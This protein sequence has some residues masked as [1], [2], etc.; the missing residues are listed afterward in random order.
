MAFHWVHNVQICLTLF[1]SA[2]SLSCRSKL[3]D[4]YISMRDHFQ[5]F[6]TTV[7]NDIIKT[8]NAIDEYGYAF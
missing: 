6:C 1:T 2:I 3:S 8:R 4:I 5:Q 7:S